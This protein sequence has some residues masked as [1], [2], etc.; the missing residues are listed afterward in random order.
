MQ[1]TEGMSSSVA[2]TGLS[3]KFDNSVSLD[4]ESE[5]EDEFH[6]ACDRVPDS[7]GLGEG[8]RAEVFTEEEIL[9]SESPIDLFITYLIRL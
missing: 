6:D 2:H 7:K 9:V 4:N 3:P 1:V 8:N 5:G